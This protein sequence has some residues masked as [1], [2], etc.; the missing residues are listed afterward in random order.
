LLSVLFSVA[1]IFGGLDFVGRASY[2]CQSGRAA[3][4]EWTALMLAAAIGA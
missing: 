2:E 1:A 3:K 4:G